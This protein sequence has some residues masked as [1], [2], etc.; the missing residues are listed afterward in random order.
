MCA[1]NV[2]MMQR[3]G[4]IGLCC[5]LGCS[6][7]VP[8][9][10]DLGADAGPMDSGVGTG[11]LDTGVSDSGV[12]D[13]GL[14][15]LGPADLGPSDLGPADLGPGDLGSLDLGPA[16]LGSPDLGSPDLG[17]PD[18]GR[19]GAADWIEM[20][21]AGA[22]VRTGTVTRRTRVESP[23]LVREAH[24]CCGKYG[25]DLR[26]TAAPADPRVGFID[27]RIENLQSSDAF[28][29]GFITYTSGF[30]V[31]VAGMEIAPGWPRWQGYDRT[32]YDGIVLDGARA[33]YAEDL[34]IRDWNADTAID[35]KA[36]ISQLVGLVIEGA[37]N[38]S[39][40]YWRPGP[41]YLVGSRLSNPGTSGDGVL[42]WFRD[43][44][45]VELRVWDVDFDGASMPSASQI[46]CDEGSSPTI[47]PLSVDP[48]STGELHPM[49]SW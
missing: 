22:P 12:W 16:D 13:Q 9:A 28:G 36:Q 5:L 11:V 3:W 17:P 46:R 44:R 26:E 35:N 20:A 10:G 6:D 27:V 40:R 21:L 41:H 19:R 38:R 34:H 8:E 48:R 30:T 14:E 33:F 45:S 29:G 32:N 4:W 47:V 42:L 15:D 1:I 39:L 18:A 7:E 25:F 24:A 49:F 2:S 37:G 31:F 23:A 43:C